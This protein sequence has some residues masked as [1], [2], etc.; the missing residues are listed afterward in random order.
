MVK[1]DMT[2]LSVSAHTDTFTRD[3]LPPATAW[4][5]FNLDAFSYPD[6]LNAAVDLTDV[7]V[8]CWLAATK[9]G[10]VVVNTMPML[11]A[12]E[13]S[14]IIDNA[15]ITHALCDARLLDELT[16]CAA[17]SIHLKH[18]FDFDG[19]SNHDATLDRLALEKTVKFDAVETGC[20]DVALLGFK[21]GTTGAPKATMH[22]HCDLMII[23]DSYAREVLSVQPEDVFVGSPPLAFTFGGLAVFHCGLERQPP[24]LKTRHRPI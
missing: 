9:A 1:H 16:N 8:A 24:Y 5:D 18:I 3:N 4:P 23:A 12:G 11:R 10:A 7:M 2:T 14:Q 22:F 19:T 21:S 20:D 15:E 6:Q 13:L 17:T